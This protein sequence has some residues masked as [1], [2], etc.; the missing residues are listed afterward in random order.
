[1][2]MYFIYRILSFVFSGHLLAIHYVENGH[3]GDGQ[4]PFLGFISFIE[5]TQGLCGYPYKARSAI[6]D[7][8]FCLSITSYSLCSLK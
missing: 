8:E 3:Q 6:Q 7:L 1:M 2:L 5:H 4:S